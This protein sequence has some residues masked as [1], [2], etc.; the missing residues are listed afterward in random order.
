LVTL[1][2]PRTAVEKVLDKIQRSHPEKTG[3]VE[4]LIKQALREL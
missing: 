2:F 1:G 3:T 4:E